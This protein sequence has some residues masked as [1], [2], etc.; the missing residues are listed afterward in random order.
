MKNT[1]NFLGIIALVA[2]IGF[3]MTAC[4]GDSGGDDD[5]GNAF[6]GSKLEISGKQ[7]YTEDYTDAGISYKQYTGSVD[8]DSSIE[9]DG[10]ITGGKLTHTIGTPAYLTAIREVSEFDYYWGNW[11]NVTI[12]DANVKAYVLTLF[13]TNY[14]YLHKENS[15]FK[16]SGTSISGT[17]EEVTYVYVDGDVTISGTGKTTTYNETYEGVTYKD[18]LKTN[19][20]NLSLKQ[21]WNAVYRKITGS[22]T[23]TATSE[24]VNDTMSL[25]LSN[26]NLKWVIDSYD[27]YDYSVLGPPKALKRLPRIGN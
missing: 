15:T 4:G 21:G 23:M 5:G 19:N 25:S 10:A 1:V 22:G 20:F 24:T 17:D 11:N 12:S 13:T 6:L 26:P 7:V 16:M 9:G 3:A 27:D 18:T 14:D 2:V 8:I